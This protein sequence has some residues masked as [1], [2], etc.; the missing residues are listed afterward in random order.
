M[1]YAMLADMAMFVHVSFVCFVLLGG[2][3][4]LRWPRMVWLHLPAALWGVTVELTGKICPLTYLENHW[5]RM[6]GGTGYQTSFVEQYL[7]PLL[8]PAGLTPGNQQMLGLFVLLL[9]LVIY[10]LIWR[11]YRMKTVR[12]PKV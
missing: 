8:Y 6:A 4:L 9:N 1:Y 12:G 2:L 3:L 11:R 10:A 7:E 5:R